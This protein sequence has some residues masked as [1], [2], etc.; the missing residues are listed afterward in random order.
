MHRTPTG[1]IALNE[2]LQNAL[3]PLT[4][5]GI[6]AGPFTLQVNDKVMQTSND[7]E[8]GFFNGDIVIVTAI[9][10]EEKAFFMT[11]DTIPVISVLRG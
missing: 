11:F 2:K 3:N 6:K 9:N 7:Y 4:G 10:K 5:E 1:T 8:K